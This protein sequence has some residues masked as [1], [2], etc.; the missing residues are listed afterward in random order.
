M[1]L[2]IRGVSPQ[3]TA[4]TISQYVP[5]EGP[6]AEPISCIMSHWYKLG[7]PDERR[8]EPLHQLRPHRQSAAAA[9]RKGWITRFHATLKACLS[10]RL[11]REAKIWRD[12]KLQGND[13]FADEI[14]AQFS[15]TAL[16]V[17]W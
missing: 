17:R 12:E 2:L 3:R 5:P 14:V 7:W 15:Q 16:L 6:Y 1:G 8:A 4:T 9:E 10:M 13:V 11:G